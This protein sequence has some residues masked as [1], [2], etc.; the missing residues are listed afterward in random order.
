MAPAL[1]RTDNHLYKSAGRFSRA[2]DEKKER[3]HNE[4][5]KKKTQN[6]L[7]SEMKS[8]SLVKKGPGRCRV[9]GQ[10]SR[11]PM[12]NLRLRPALRALCSQEP[13]LGQKPCGNQ[14]SSHTHSSVTTARRE[15]GRTRLRGKK[16]KKKVY[17]TKFQTVSNHRK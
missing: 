12:E 11:E 8:L 9:A 7:R 14:P 16:R 2:G 13:R 15:Q 5:K 3:G 4:Q 17:D 10:S 1:M 6:D